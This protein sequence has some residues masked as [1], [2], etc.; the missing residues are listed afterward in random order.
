MKK[1]VIIRA[2]GNEL[3][4]QLWNYASIYAY[5]RERKYVLENPAFFEYGEYFTI[6]APS[7]FTKLF[8]FLPFKNYTKRKTALRRRIWRK[9]YARY[10]DFIISR[11]Q[12]DLMSSVNKDNIP[13]YLPPTKESAGMLKELEQRSGDIY[14]DG[15]LSRNPVG[16]EQYHGEILKFFEPRADIKQK[17]DATMKDLH[18]RY[19][20]IVGVHIRQGDYQ[21]W[22]DGA[23][24]INQ[25]RVR[26]IL[27]EYLSFSKKEPNEVCFLITSD[28]PIDK[29]TFSSGL[30]IVVSNSNA[31][32]DLFLLASTDVVIGSN[33]TFG[34]FAAYYG[35]IP[36]IVMQEEVIDWDYYQGKTG[37]FENKY[38]TMVHY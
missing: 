37:F 34:A 23:Y 21:T 25:K 32:A 11:H 8:F 19:E 10:T 4:N 26:V 13:C 5:C 18:A 12:D 6:P 2:A 7:F 36:F 29:D 9:L 33:S 35:N 14:F 20:H 31:V 17:I 3:A 15:W 1:V 22:R 27:N 24:F 30:N 38:S 28:G 16:L